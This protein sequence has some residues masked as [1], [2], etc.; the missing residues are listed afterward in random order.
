MY[1]RFTGFQ[2][3]STPLTL[4]DSAAVNFLAN[5]YAHGAPPV[6]NFSVHALVSHIGNVHS[7]I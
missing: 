2:L 1:N 4:Q 6:L 5:I 7:L 3:V